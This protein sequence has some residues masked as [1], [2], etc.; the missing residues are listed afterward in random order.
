MLSPHKDRSIFL[1][2]CANAIV[3]LLILMTLLSRDNRLSL[4]SAA[5]AQMPAQAPIAGASGLF[6]M[7][8]QLSPNTW[9][10]YLLDSQKQTLC[11]YQFLPGDKLLRFMAARDVGHDHQL[12][13]FNTLPP[14]SDIK[15]LVER[16]NQGQQATPSAPKPP[17]PVK[18]Q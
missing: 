1:A 12:S 5:F 15:D 18:E 7:P 8:A 16:E 4:S 2:L 17:E 14:P 11:V 6:I 13:D 9:G 3:L 10:C